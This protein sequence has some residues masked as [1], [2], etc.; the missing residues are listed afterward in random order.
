MNSRNQPQPISTQDLTDYLREDS[1]FA[2]EMRVREIFASKDLRIEHGG[3]YADPHSGLPRQFDLQADLNCRLWKSPLKLFLAAEC[4]SLSEFAPMLVYRSLRSVDEAGHQLIATTCKQ[5]LSGTA[6]RGCAST[7]EE[8]DL[9]VNQQAA[10]TV[11][12]G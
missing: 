4:K 9:H 11:T 8:V 7:Q 5:R 10:I 1:S 2:F 3:T 6:I 12:S